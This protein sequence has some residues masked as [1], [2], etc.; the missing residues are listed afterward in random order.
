MSQGE[1]VTHDLVSCTRL[2]DDK[3][4]STRSIFLRRHHFDLF[5]SRSVFDAVLDNTHLIDMPSRAAAD[6]G[7]AAF[8]P[9][10]TTVVKFLLNDN[11]AAFYQSA[12]RWTDEQNRAVIHVNGVPMEDMVG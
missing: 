11:I 3:D 2:I 4:H 9:V 5:K 6:A 10:V 1:K 8:E 7:I 12:D